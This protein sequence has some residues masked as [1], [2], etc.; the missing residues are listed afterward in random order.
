MG[1]GLHG[2]LASL[3]ARLWPKGTGCQRSCTGASASARHVSMRLCWHCVLQDGAVGAQHGWHVRGRSQPEQLAG[4][5]AR[6]FRRTR[7]SELLLRSMAAA[8]GTP[9]TIQGVPAERASSASSASSGHTLESYLSYCELTRPAV[10]PLLPVLPPRRPKHSQQLAISK[11]HQKKRLEKKR[12]GEEK[13]NSPHLIHRPRLGSGA[14]GQ[15]EALFDD[16]L[17]LG[18]LLANA[19]YVFGSIVL[20]SV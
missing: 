1:R 11:R 15:E 17:L 6:H 14:S 10:L 4:R 19:C 16:M 9:C 12:P 2:K 13:R 18:T 20:M 8:G 5:L 3:L 7:V